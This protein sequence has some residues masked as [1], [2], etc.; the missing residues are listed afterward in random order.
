MFLYSREMTAEDKS[1]GL[2]CPTVT[3]NSQRQVPATHLYLIFPWPYGSDTSALPLKW[4][5]QGFFK[6]HITSGPKTPL[7]SITVL[8]KYKVLF[9]QPLFFFF[10]LL[11]GWWEMIS[12]GGRWGLWKP[13][14]VL[15]CSKRWPAER[16]AE[17]G[18][19]RP[20]GLE[21]GWRC[22]EGRLSPWSRS[23]MG[24]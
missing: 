10:F 23:P 9:L 2:F 3:T 14:D 17:P 8:V 15:T 6:T 16:P 21:A 11:R 22:R 24:F 20:F 18:M 4:M 1:P 12:R 7:F 19:W 5:K 13:C